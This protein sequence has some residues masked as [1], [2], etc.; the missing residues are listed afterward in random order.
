MT[1]IREF[2]PVVVRNGGESR[3]W[4]TYAKN[5]YFMQKLLSQ[6]RYII[7]FNLILV[8]HYKQLNAVSQYGLCFLYTLGMTALLCVDVLIHRVV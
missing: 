5:L 1:C 2:A 4:Q 7:D 6:I 3:E 8:I